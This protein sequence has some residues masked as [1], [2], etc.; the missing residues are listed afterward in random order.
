MKTKK[1]LILN[2][3]TYSAAFLLFG[4]H[5]TKTDH[6]KQNINQNQEDQLNQLSANSFFLEKN[7][8][9]NKINNNTENIITNKSEIKNDI[10]PLEQQKIEEAFEVTSIIDGDTIEIDYN[11]KKK[12]V[13]FLGIDSSEMNVNG[14]EAQCYAR[15]ARNFLR[16]KLENKKV[17]LST[18]PENFNIDENDRLLRYVDILENNKIIRLNEELVKNGFARAAY[19]FPLSQRGKYVGLE[20]IAKKNKLGLWKAC[21]FENLPKFFE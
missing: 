6:K 13:R 11:N 16:E 5:L 21:T 9:N 19:E 3:C 15:A 4:Y 7:E 20:L 8:T 14:N 17:Y 2:L 10:Q 12:Q 1:F 18:D